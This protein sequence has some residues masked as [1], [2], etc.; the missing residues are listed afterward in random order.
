MPRRQWRERVNDILEA[1]ARI[2]RYTREFDE[3]SFL[4]D[5]RTVDAVIRNISLIGE[6]AT[7]IPPQL[8]TAHPGVPWE[9]M[10]GMRNVLIH[11]YFD[12]GLDILWVTIQD[13]LPALKVRL[14]TLLENEKS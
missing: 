8:Q 14:R 12:I 4:A 7:H 13:D 3:A 6:A 1:I 2:E 10:R 5:E 11:E 9:L